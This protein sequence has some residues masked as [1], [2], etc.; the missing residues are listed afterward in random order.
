MTIISPKAL[1][2]P[3]PYSLTQRELLTMYR[4]PATRQ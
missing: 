1:L 2:T 4:H 3:S